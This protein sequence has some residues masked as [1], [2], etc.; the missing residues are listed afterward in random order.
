MNIAYVISGN[1][2]DLSYWSGTA[3]YILQILRKYHNVH[4]VGVGMLNQALAFSRTNFATPHSLESYSPLLAK[5]CSERIRRIPNLDLVFFGDI[6]L[7]ALLTIDVPFVHLSDTTFH[8]MLEYRNESRA[9]YVAQMERYEGIALREKYDAI[10][11]SSP[12]PKQ[13]AIYYYNCPDEKIHVVELGANIPTPTDYK[14]D[15]YSSVCNLLYISSDWN[16]KQGDKV[17][18][19][20]LEL[21]KREFPCTLTCIGSTPQHR[22]PFIDGISFIPHIDKSKASEM[23]Q[24]CSI[25]REAHFLLL[26]TLF[27]GFGIVFCEASAYALPSIA[28]RVGGTSQAIQEGKNGYLLPLYALVKD[29]ADKIMEVYSDRDTYIQLR[30]QSRKEFETRLNWDKWMQRVNTIFER[31]VRQYKNER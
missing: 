15:N 6:Y 25:L 11:F 24:L 14:V 30:M 18:E 9:P 3:Y 21:R 19:I 23:K 4:L 12:W 26:P 16:R 1:P 10:I 28:T 2:N 22:I 8:Q 13:L 27:E 29:F 17:I 31:V 20:F 7:D 5:L